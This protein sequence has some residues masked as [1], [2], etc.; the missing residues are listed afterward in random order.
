MRPVGS[1]FLPDPEGHR[2]L[3]RQTVPALP[4]VSGRGP[5]SPR[6]GLQDCVLGEHGRVAWLQ[7][8]PWPPP[9]LAVP[10]ICGTS[11]PGVSKI[12][13]VD[14]K[15]NSPL[16]LKVKDLAEGMTYRFRIRAK[17]FAYGPEIEANVTTGPGE[18][19]GAQG[20]QESCPPHPV[21][22]PRVRGGVRSCA[23]SW[24]CGDAGGRGLVGTE[25]QPERGQGWGRGGGGRKGAHPGHRQGDLSGCVLP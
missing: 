14:V 11:F 25:P 17:T 13:T 18:G 22:S 19:K 8:P 4:N 24:R 5:L 16:W 23:R 15:G 1:C 10:H 7:G 2:V 12:V 3:H 20:R 6:T 9:A 21:F